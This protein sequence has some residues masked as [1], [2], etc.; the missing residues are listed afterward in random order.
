M[1][2][3]GFITILYT[4]CAYDPC[5]FDLVCEDVYKSTSIFETII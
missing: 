3:D 2:T 1:A 4:S 5:V